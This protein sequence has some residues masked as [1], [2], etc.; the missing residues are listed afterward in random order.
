MA[1]SF[2]IP[3][4]AAT[5]FADRAD[6]SYQQTDI[7]G[8]ERDQADAV[9]GCAKHLYQELGDWL[10]VVTLSGHANPGHVYRAGMPPDALSFSMQATAT[11]SSETIGEG[12]Q[13]ERSAAE[14]ATGGGRQ[15]RSP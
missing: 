14:R 7:S 3:A 9:L 11:P 1:W 6:R 13:A 5:D 2:T 8:L 12:R 4:G 15:E 10:D